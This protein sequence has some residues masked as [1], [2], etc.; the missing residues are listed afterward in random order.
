[1]RRVI[2]V[3]I[4]LVVLLIVDRVAVAT[5]ERDLA[6]RIAAVPNFSDTPTVSIEGRYP[7][8]RFDLGT[9]SK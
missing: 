3:L 1:M 5:V 9:F 6:N 8:V 4:A 7:E 2:V